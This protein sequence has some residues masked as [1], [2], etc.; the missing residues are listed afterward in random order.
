MDKKFRKPFLGLIG[1]YFAI[2]LG[3]RLID[4]PV[5]QTFV[6][7]VGV[8]LVG[9][10]TFILEYISDS[11]TFELMV[12]WLLLI[13]LGFIGVGASLG[14]FTEFNVIV[15]LLAFIILLAEGYIFYNASGIYTDQEDEE[16]SS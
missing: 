1:M 7:S 6:A 3:S 16:V 14:T 2:F 8:M 15:G 12:G 9:I 13:V 4:E 10:V 11:G 5:I